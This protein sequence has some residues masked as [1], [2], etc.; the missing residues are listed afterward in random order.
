MEPIDVYNACKAAGMDFVTISDHNCICGAKSIA[1]LP[2]TF[3]S[4]ELTTYFP[5]NGCKIHCLVSGITER[6]FHEMSDLRENIYDL[7]GYMLQNRIV[8]TIAHPLFRI[9][10][11]LTID[12][13]EK[14]LL[15]FNRFEG[16]NG[17]RDSRACNISNAVLQNLTPDMINEMA[18]RHGIRPVGLEPWN[19]TLTGGSD[20]HG[21]LY[22]AS[23]YTITPAAPSVIDFLEYLREGQHEAG[24]CGGTS[25]RLANSLYRIAYDY[26]KSRFLS[27][28]AADRSVIG[29]ILRR[30]A[31]QPEEIAQPEIGFRAALKSGL[32]KKIKKAYAKRQLSDIE[33]MIVEEFTRVLESGETPT[34]IGELDSANFRSACRLSQELSYT[35]LKKAANKIHKGELIGSLQ[36]I[37]SLGP[38]ALG[39]AP[40]L[41]AFST[42][43]KDER[44][45]REVAAHFPAA[46]RLQAKSGKRAWVTDTFNDVNG[47][48][49]TIRTLAGMAQENQYDITVVTS[50]ETEPEASFPLKNFKPIGTF[51]MPEYQSIEISFPPFMELLAY[52][53]QEQFDEIIISTP[54]PLGL[55]ALSAAR[56]LGLTTKGIYHTDFPRFFADITEDD[57]LGEVAW[58]CMRWFYGKVDKILVPTRQY[59]QLLMNGGFEGQEIDIMPRGI[60]LKKFNPSFRNLDIWAPYGLNGNFKFIY[61]GRV[62]RE[63]NIENLLKAFTRLLEEGHKA[64][65]VV[66]G[67]GPEREK[68]AKHYDHPQITFT[69]YLYGEELAQA[70]ASADMLVFPSLT[71]TFGNV[72]LEA[73]ACGLP[74]I[75]SDEGG[76]QEIVQSHQ[77]GIVVN[78]RTPEG[79][80]TAM[81]QIIS[82]PAQYE[83][84]RINAHQKAASSRWEIALEKLLC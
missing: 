74:A 47:V 20:D 33:Q 7:Q 43:H 64:D 65:L 3:I 21:G 75:V 14:L 29:A 68:L 63:K 6:Q 28:G 80:Y 76:P 50:L 54:G 77:S 69:G 49:K 34:P 44:F 10:D 35:F 78:A 8:H 26:Y 71:D 39:I 24:G 56:M 19:K 66:V 5:E 55:C 25:V 12:L 41:T 40:Y 53:E 73:H 84:L 42:Q 15:L 36:A 4:S 9:N 62:S 30:M 67:D 61:A 52:F 58:K 11:K 18:D 81:R 17:S 16:I 46:N 60:N 1:H 31:E 70:Y 22:I 72:V 32:R 57:A 23:A 83:T 79:L 48:T 37:S 38:V 27:N 82:D 51:K 13:F 2:G 59:K 45:L